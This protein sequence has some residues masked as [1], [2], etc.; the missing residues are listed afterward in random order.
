M[1]T[2]RVGAAA[3]AAA[4]C[5][6][7]LSGP[8]S[9]IPLPN[10]GSFGNCAGRFGAKCVT[11]KDV[12]KGAERPATSGKNKKQTPARAGSGAAKP[13][14]KAP[15]CTTRAMDPQPP[16]NSSERRGFNGKGALITGTVYQQ[17]CVQGEGDNVTVIDFVGGAEGG[18]APAPAV[19]PVVLAQQAV[20]SMLLEGPKI[21]TAPK[22]GATGLVGLPVWMWS[23]VSPT[24]TG[25]NSASATAGAVTVTATARVT[26]IQWSTG[27]GGSVTCAGPGTPYSAAYGKKPSPTCGHTYTRTSGKQPGAKYTLTATSTWAIEWQVQG[28]GLGGELTETRTAVPQQLAIGEAQAVGS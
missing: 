11:A 18:G 17:E 25:P 1:R 4:M 27:D 24:T 23:A 21:Q 5:S 7:L 10:D 26:S 9:A 20:D 8:A 28:S 19:D 12:K 13:D 2:A 6:V 14:P 15:V 3:T 22:K 16:A